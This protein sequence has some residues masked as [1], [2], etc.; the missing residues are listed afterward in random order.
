MVGKF[1]PEADVHRMYTTAQEPLGGESGQ[2]GN[3]PRT[4]PFLK[5]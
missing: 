3:Q 2:I 4:Q 1:E 5:S